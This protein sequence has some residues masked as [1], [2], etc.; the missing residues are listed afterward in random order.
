MPRALLNGNAIT[1]WTSFHEQCRRAFGFPEFYANTMDA[2]VDCLSYLRDDPFAT[3]DDDESDVP[4]SRLANNA[5][6]SNTDDNYDEDE[7][8]DEDFSFA[9]RSST[10]KPS[11]AADLIADSDV[12]E[13]SD[14][15]P[16]VPVA[17]SKSQSQPTTNSRG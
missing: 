2:W 10:R 6:K 12:S 3:T 11:S 5:I 16:S 17:G 1:D 7:D 4:L 15:V 14:S 9:K 8:E 13:S